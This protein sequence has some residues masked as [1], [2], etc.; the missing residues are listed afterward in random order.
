MNKENT[1]TSADLQHLLFIKKF[2]DL[3]NGRIEPESEDIHNAKLGCEELKTQIRDILER[4][5]ALDIKDKISVIDIFEHKV[6]L[7]LR[8]Y[9]EQSTKPW[10]QNKL[11]IA[12]MG[13]LKT[14][15]TSAMNCFFGED[16]PTGSDEA[17]A[18][19]TY[20][21]EGDNPDQTAL[22][23]DKEGGMQEITAEQL[24]LFSFDKS[25]KFPFPRM[26]S[27][28]AKKSHHPALSDKTFIDTPG[29][30]SSNSE[31]S[32]PTYNV[33]DYCDVVF[34]FIN[35]RKFISDK[36]DLPFI[37]KHLSDKPV[38][39]IFTFI[40]ARG[41]NKAEI[42]EIQEDIKQ[43]LAK[44]GITIQGYILF[45]KEKDTQE[46]FKK[47]FEKIIKSLGNSYQTVN[48]ILQINKF[49]LDLQKRIL[50][51]LENMT[52]SKN[53]NKNELDKMNNIIKQSRRSVET[54][55]DSVKYR[56]K[57]LNDTLY[58]RCANVWFCQGTYNTLRGNVE[59]LES[60]L[61]STIEEAWHNVDYDAIARYG[62]LSAEIKRQED[63]IAR[64]D[65]INTDINNILN[66]L[67]HECDKV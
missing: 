46:Q 51:Y 59:Q 4:I 38:Y 45:G 65:A 50:N 31:H 49:L 27:Y 23:V 28:I 19:A 10:L 62:H 34:W 52:K 61:S 64:L 41:T 2:Q 24:Q 43:K 11:T 48:P 9:V 60:S 13:H 18:L 20:L 35:I 22:L 21:Y 17:T 42:P 8:R 67:N 14:G 15:K 16:F 29:L 47:D 36:S 54:A 37:K 32:K 40:D 6:D 12:L 26:F 55:F 7:P 25:F 3:L 56:F 5:K 1:L 63:V 30:F 33:I 57:N 39:I 53:E 66:K 58:N 44:D